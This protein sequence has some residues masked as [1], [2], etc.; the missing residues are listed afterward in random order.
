MSARI[1]APRPT[2]PLNAEFWDNCR[3][4]RLCFQYCN[5]CG[6][7]QHLPRYMCAQCGA[8]DWEW[9]ESSGRG[10]IFSWT[11]TRRAL[12]PAF[13]DQLPYATIVVE[14]EE[15]VRM[16]TRLTGL[17]PDDLKLDLPVELVWEPIAND[18][19]LPYFRP[20]AA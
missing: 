14:M 2:D 15:G 11:V 5:G 7:F 18:M 10:K 9:R 6:R 19:N 16:I 20:R 17:D 8:A 1:P 3:D 12:H 4:R 13:A